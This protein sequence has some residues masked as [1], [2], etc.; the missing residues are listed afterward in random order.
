MVTR[1]DAGKSERKCLAR[2]IRASTP[3][4][5]VPR[6]RTSRLAISCSAGW[7]PLLK[8]D[9][10]AD[11]FRLPSSARTIGNEISLPRLRQG[12]GSVHNLELTIIQAVRIFSAGGY[13]PL[14]APSGYGERIKPLQAS[15]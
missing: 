3:P 8:N 10:A 11:E 6:A 12:A 1:T 2:E 15:F 13:D 4:A 5:E 14:L 9:R 7:I